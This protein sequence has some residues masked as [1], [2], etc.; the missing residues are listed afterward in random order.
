MK[1]ILIIDDEPAARYGLRRALELSTALPADSAQY[2]RCASHQPDL[3]CRNGVA[4]NGWTLLLKLL[5]DQGNQVPVL[6]ISALDA[7]NHYRSCAWSGGLLVKGL[8]DGCQRLRS[9]EAR[10]IGTGKRRCGVN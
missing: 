6:M 1:T 4:R 3:C 7:A 9:L 10:D 5:H 8:T 2:S